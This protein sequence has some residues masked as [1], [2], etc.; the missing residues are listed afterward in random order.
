MKPTNVIR[1]R[2][3]IKVIDLGAVRAI[4]ST[5]TEA[6]GT[7]GF[8]VD[9]DE[10][11]EHGLTVRSDLHTVGKTL[12]VLYQATDDAINDRATKGPRS[13]GLRSLRHV[14]ERAMDHYDR[15]YASADE[16][17]EQLTGVLREIVA[18]PDG[19][20]QRRQSTVFVE[21]T[22]LLDA[23]LG[24]VPALTHWLDHDVKHDESPDIG[25]PKPME[26]ALA[27][28]AP[29]VRIDDPG[30]SVLATLTAT[31]PRQVLDSLSR[32]VTSESAEIHLR[33]C[34]AL[35]ELRDLDAA[36]ARLLDAEGLLSGADWRISWYR[37][38]IELAA[39]DVAA[40]YAEFE[41]VYR[42]LPGEEA[43]KLALGL[44]AEIKGRLPEAESFYQAVWLREPVAA[45]AAFGLARI[46][47]ANGRQRKA[48]TKLNEI[49]DA[50]R[51]AQEARIAAIRLRCGRPA[52][53]PGLP[54]DPD[55]LQDAVNRL[56]EL[57][58]VDAGE[59]NGPTRVRLTALVLAAAVQ[60]AESCGRLT[61][62]DGG[63]V[64]GSAETPRQLRVLLEQSLRAL[65]D[66]A[67]TPR[68]H[69]ALVDRANAVRPWT[70]L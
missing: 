59:R 30:A 2:D 57:S 9:K 43:P 52:S 20:V 63:D 19:P 14:Y 42:D 44:C 55:E 33:A 65:A 15:R 12:Q 50:S 10:V 67:H 8:R 4:D 68:E 26:I 64:F 49:G 35:I 32:S 51:H 41:A 62:I 21:P 66:Q 28:P 3:R 61:G 38:L 22:V 36:R 16:M 53:G 46:E 45:T 6:F 13:P 39:A 23:G 40:A 54:P 31:E 60:Q 5:E 70:L 18:G 27:L 7:D 69:S 56:K 17:A 29:L 58:T 25:P 34:R 1:G 48:V 47:L 11:A 24:G 37:G